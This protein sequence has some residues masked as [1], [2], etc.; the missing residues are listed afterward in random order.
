MPR[1]GEMSGGGMRRLR[2]ES[3]QALIE[4]VML[5]PLVLVFLLFII[6]FGFAMHTFVTVN[7][8]AS[9]AARYAA[10]ANL[11][12]N[13]GPGS[14]SIEQRAVDAS[15]GLV[16]CPEV[17]VAYQKP[18]GQPQ[19]LRGDGVRVGI[20]HVY[21]PLTP[22][23]SLISVLSLG[24]IPDSW[25]MTACSDARLEQ[26]PLDQTALSPGSDCSGP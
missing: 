15:A 26:R 16:K 24:A 14:V 11:P 10:V 17:L 2:S 1:N 19:Y 6:E 23:G 13:C 18:A 22:L 21:T 20:K 4:F 25:I 3:G 5:F 9:E 12:G 8:T 7:N